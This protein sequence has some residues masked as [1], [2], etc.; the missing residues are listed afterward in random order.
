MFKDR[1]DGASAR[2]VLILSIALGSQQCHWLVIMI[3]T[4]TVCWIV[5]DAETEGSEA[6]EKENVTYSITSEVKFYNTR[7]SR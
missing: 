3:L 4:G 5:D 1:R 2:N 7:V 6:D